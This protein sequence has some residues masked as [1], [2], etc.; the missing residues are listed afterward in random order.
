VNICVYETAFIEKVKEAYPDASTPLKVCGY[1]DD[2]REAQAAAD[3]L[4]GAGYTSVTVMQGGLQD[5]KAGGGKTEGTGTIGSSATGYRQI[6]PET[7]F[8]RWTGRNLFNFHT[9]ALKLR[10]GHVEL[11]DGR[12]VGGTIRVDMESLSCSDL[13]DSK[14]NRMLIDHLRS[15]D[16]FSVAD[17]PAATF[18]VTS[19]EPIVGCTAGM[20]SHRITG[21]LTVRG[22]TSP[23]SFEA[24]VAEK[25]DGTFTAQATPD[26][27]RTVFGSIYGSGKF[28]SR[29]GQHVV[30]D[31]VH[32]HL[33]VVTEPS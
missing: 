33:K 20:P 23:I 30:N 6:D 9:G 7:S 3:R 10:D 4:K 15:D 27:D 16:F 29:L 28:F 21:D 19:S 2:T 8:I 25:D 22:K 18:V 13:T 14:M 12:L 24:L 1:S 32:L 17:H 26:F 5:W 11:N 31:L